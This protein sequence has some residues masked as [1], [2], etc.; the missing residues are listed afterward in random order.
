M[1]NENSK[2]HWE[3]IYQTKSMNEVSWYQ[4]KPKTS[5]EFLQQA[6]L[7]KQASIIDIG[8]GDS[9]L[10]DNLI[11]LGYTNISVLDIS[12]SALERAK[13]RLGDKASIVKWIVAD[14]SDFSPTETYDFWHD[15]AAFHFLTNEEAIAKYIATAQNAINK[16][17]HLIVG[18]FSNSGPKKCSG[19]EIKQY[20]E[21]ELTSRFAPYFDKLQCKIEDHATPFDT[22]QNFIFCDFTKH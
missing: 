12:Q 20:T 19:L 10:V 22:T 15:R 18:T 13:Q 9:F 14:A 5:L 17:G 2:N 1:E 8:G 4:Q 3:T 7:P 16:E 21:E 11:E 6:N